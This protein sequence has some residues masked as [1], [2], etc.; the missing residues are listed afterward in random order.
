MRR[1]TS[2]SSGRVRDRVPNSYAGAC[3]AQLNRQAAV[4]GID[5]TS[6]PVSDLTLVLLAACSQIY[7]QVGPL[8]DADTVDDV[9]VLKYGGV[10]LVIACSARLDDSDETVNLLF[11]KVRNLARL[12]VDPAL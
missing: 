3:A 10:D 1:L 2:R 8:S 6:R 11:L 4:R 12:A 7:G 9:G 5:M